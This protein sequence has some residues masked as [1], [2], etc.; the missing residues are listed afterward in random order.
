MIGDHP[1]GEALAKS[2][3]A[4]PTLFSGHQLH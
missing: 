3:A 4:S 2:I 1:I